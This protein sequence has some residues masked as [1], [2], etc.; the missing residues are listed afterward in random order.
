MALKDAFNMLLKRHSRTGQISRPG[1]TALPIWY[2]PTNYSRSLQGPS[3]TV[4]EGREFVITKKALEESA[5]TGPLKRGDR[6]IDTELGTLTMREIE[7]MFDYGGS[8][9]GYRVRT[10]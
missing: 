4:F 6:L 9:V 2:T 1:G 10:D 3:E 5:F 7:E 8:V